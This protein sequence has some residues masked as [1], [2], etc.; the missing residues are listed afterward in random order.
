[1]EASC[2]GDEN[3]EADSE[4]RRD[5][6]HDCSGGFSRL[7]TVDLELVLTGGERV[8]GARFCEEAS[9]ESF[10]A[11]VGRRMKTLEDAGV[12]D[13]SGEGVETDIE[14]L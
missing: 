14:V 2:P 12:R 6:P 9:A 1:M 5:Y 8:G 7:L 10:V 11:G 4:R 13:W 3:E